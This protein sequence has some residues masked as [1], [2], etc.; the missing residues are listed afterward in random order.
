[1]TIADTSVPDVL[2]V[3]I[4]R[5]EFLVCVLAEPRET[6]ALVEELDVSR[7]TVDRGMSALETV[8]LVE[9][10]GD[11]YQTTSI[12]GV[13]TTDFLAFLDSVEEANRNGNPI[14]SD[15][16]ALEVVDT[17]ASRRP[18]LEVLR[19]EPKDKR[20]LVDELEMSRST[21]DRG[22]RELNTLGLVEYSDNGFVVT[23][24]GELAVEGLSELASTIEL[25]QQMETFLQWV[26]MEEFDLD[27]RLLAD[28][29]ILVAEPGNPYAMI[30]S[31]VQL[32]KTM[33]NCRAFLPFTGLHAH[34]AAHQQVVEHNASGEI[35]G[36][37]DIIDVHMSNPKYAELA[38]EIVATGRFE[39]FEYPEEL[40]YALALIDD[41]V[42]VVV[43]EGDEPRALLETE[44]DEVRNWAERK[45]NGYKKQ[46]K[47]VK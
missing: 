44:D 36:E 47:K 12:G 16:P 23:P 9:P 11:S 40:P 15:V 35:V 37:P 33:D 38:E 13:V 39:Y 25:G 21:V 18:L 24:I 2:D 10:C 20:V 1:M 3:L 28:A 46:S 34:E 22:V 14:Q 17:V 26:P 42:Q 19:G 32:I 6:S 8:G 4:Q 27:V 31:H 30:N 29:E 41:T 43:A 7:S 45:Y 5:S